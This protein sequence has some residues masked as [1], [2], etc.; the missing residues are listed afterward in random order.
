MRTNFSS[1]I[2]L[3]SLFVFLIWFIEGYQFVDIFKIPL[4]IYP[5][6]NII[7]N[8]FYYFKFLPHYFSFQLIFY[9]SNF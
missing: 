8:K 5:Y 4:H 2:Y 1:W 6:E 7:L 3:F 9:L